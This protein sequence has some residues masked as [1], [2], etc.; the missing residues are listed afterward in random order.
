MR[1]WPTHLAGAGEA[2]AAARDR[3]ITTLFERNPDRFREFS[4][5]LGDML[6]DFSKT[7]LDAH[8]LTLLIELAEARGVPARRDA[9]LR[10]DRINTT[11]DRAVLHTALRNRAST[12]IMVDGRT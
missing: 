7:N 1:R 8:A 9:M 10:G 4:V 12:P 2:G 5:R 6:L 11:E 3:R